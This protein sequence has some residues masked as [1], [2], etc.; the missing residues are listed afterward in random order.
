MDRLLVALAA[1]VGSHLLLS[2]PLRAPLVGRIGEGGFRLVY[3]L[4]AL[5]TLIWMMRIYRRLDEVPIWVAPGWAWPAGSVVML[6]AAVLFVGSLTPANR[7]L[8]G[9]P[10]IERAPSG[11][12]RITRHPMM[13]AFALWAL[14]HGVLA[15]DPP[16]LALT[17]SIGFLA[18]VGAALQDRKKAV[19]DPGWAAHA[20]RT[21]WWPLGAQIAGRQPWRALWPGAVPV[22]GG[23]AL[24][25]L[26]SWL[27]PMLGAPAVGVW[28]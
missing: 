4:V 12:L 26:A 18:L 27:H 13:W 10:G 7:A 25:L 16:T 2:H 24:W 20:A 22:A 11:V 23:A 1:F 9:A 21:S 6:L 14:V 15:G 17:A 8:A 28:R 3:S 19:L 5:G